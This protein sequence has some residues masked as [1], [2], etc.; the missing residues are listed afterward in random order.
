VPRQAPRK[1]LASALGYVV[2]LLLALEIGVRLAWK[3]DRNVP[4][5][6]PHRLIEGFY[7]QLN[8]IKSQSIQPDDAY[9]DV[10]LLGGSVTS[11]FYAV[12]RLLYEK[13]NYRTSR[14][15]RIHNASHPA[16][17]S[18]DSLY[19]YRALQDQSF[20]LV[21]IYHGINETR[22]NN[23]PPD[24]FQADYSH[25]AWYRLIRAI[26]QHKEL[27]YTVLPYTLHFLWINLQD[28]LGSSAFIP[29][30]QTRPEWLH[31]GET[32]KTAAPFRQN[33]TDILRLAERKREPVFLMTFAY[34]IAD[35]YTQ[36]QFL[37]KT[38]D[39]T[40][41]KPETPIEMW[42]TPDNVAKGIEV[43]NAIIRELARQYGHAELIDQQALMP[44]SGRYYL[45]ICHLTI[46]G[47]TRWVEPVLRAL[48]HATPEAAA[49][50]ESQDP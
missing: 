32:I 44:A 15:A 6:Q 16:H 22:T 41:H 39:Y 38:L 29:F 14:P 5:F 47:A 40:L 31:Y 24:V 3:L 9:F 34:Y 11:K 25:Y 49:R 43:H 21:I 2:L 20:D 30:R 28:A 17:T 50:S 23:C 35:G 13:L 4:F 45:D 1:R 37:N 7:K 27:P 18:L 36:E 46:D 48:G 19:K 12:E 26:R 42:G 10:L 8:V 33:L